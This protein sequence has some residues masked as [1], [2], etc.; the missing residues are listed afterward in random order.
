MKLNKRVQWVN[1]RKYIYVFFIVLL[2]VFLVLISC[3]AQKPKA[4]SLDDFVSVLDKSQ[5]FNDYKADFKKGFGKDF[6]PVLILNSTLNNTIA[7][8]KL[9]SNDT[10]IL[11]ELYIDLPDMS[12]K[13]LYE[14]RMQDSAYS[15]RGIVAVLDMNEKTVVKFFA[16]I[17]VQM[18]SNLE[19]GG[20]E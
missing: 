20:N 15:D 14:V 2:L 16:T 9:N 4:Y 18:G 13:S 10:S 7:E 3:N 6:S 8:Q 11:R 5:D 19:S 17:G 1:T 12:E